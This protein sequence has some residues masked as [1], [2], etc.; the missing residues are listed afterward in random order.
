ME[1]RLLFIALT[2]TQLPPR[3]VFADMHVHPPHLRNCRLNLTTIFPTLAHTWLLFA[4]MF[5]EEEEEVK[6]ASELEEMGLA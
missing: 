4:H 6:L 1:T 3:A 2:T 5:A